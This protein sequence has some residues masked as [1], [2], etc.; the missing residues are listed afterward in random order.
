MEAGGSCQAGNFDD[1]TGGAGQASYSY[2]PPLQMTCA[3][4]SRI[5]RTVCRVARVP[6]R[7]LRRAAEHLRHTTL[8]LNNGLSSKSKRQA[9]PNDPSKVSCRSIAGTR[10]RSS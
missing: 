7:L 10:R 8:F 3:P 5:S 1:G 4:T 6:D 2:L 9:D